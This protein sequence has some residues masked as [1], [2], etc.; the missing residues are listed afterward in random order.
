MRSLR[1]ILAAAILAAAA[2]LTVPASAIDLE[3]A[4]AQGLVGETRSGYVAPVN[5][6]TADVQRLVNGVNAKRRDH[7]QKIAGRNGISIDEVGRLTAEKLINGLP[8]GVYYQTASGSWQ[9]K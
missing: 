8:G 5:S 1:N 2:L 3:S 7:Y 9:R 6:P 4:R